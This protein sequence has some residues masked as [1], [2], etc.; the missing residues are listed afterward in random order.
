MKQLPTNR[1]ILLD[2]DGVINVDHTP[3]GTVSWAEFEFI[4]GSLDALRLLTQA[5]YSLAIITNQSCVGKGLI[6]HATLDDIHQRMSQ[7]I[8]EHG[9]HIHRIY[10]CTDHPDHPTNRRKPASGMIRE[11]LSDFGAEAATTPMIGDS[12]RDL[13]AAHDAGCPRIL[14]RTGKGEETLQKGL[15]DC[16]QPVTIYANLLEAAQNILA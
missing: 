3:H 12:L 13:Q 2:R 6:S 8:S 14:T 5:G 4:A 1:L 11:A 16:L 15:P 7:I 9:G 10:S